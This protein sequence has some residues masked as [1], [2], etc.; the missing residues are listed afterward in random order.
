MKSLLPALNSLLFYFFVL[1]LSGCIVFP[2]SRQVSPEI[3]GVIMIDDKPAIG[4][5]II[6]S[7]ATNAIGTPHDIPDIMV[8][9]DSEGT[10]YLKERR[11]N[12]IV[13]SIG[14]DYHST[15]LILDTGHHKW[16]IHESRCIHETR[17]K[18]IYI[19]CDL[20]LGTESHH[21]K[22]DFIPYGQC[23]EITEKNQY[24]GKTKGDVMA[25]L[26]E[27]VKK[28]YCRGMPPYGAEVWEYNKKKIGSR[29]RFLTFSIAKQIVHNSRD[30]FLDTDDCID[31]PESR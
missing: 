7:Y 29:Y 3:S 16:I 26:G 31:M 10:F 4:A 1:Q 18:E 11:I 5:K 19:E 15:R 30:K 28:Y 2:E 13:S 8:L 14:D 23:K 20:H 12:T 25:A 9:T 24:I 6:G 22:E 17:V 21:S 27:P